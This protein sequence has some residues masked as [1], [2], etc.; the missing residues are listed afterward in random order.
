MLWADFSFESV[1][2]FKPPEPT[3]SAPQRLTLDDPRVVKRY[4]KV[5]KQEHRRLKL[6]KRGFDIQAAIPMGL[7]TS[8]C[9]EY[10]KL[11]H[12]DSCAR[13]HA[14]KKCRKLTMGAVPFSED[15]KKATSAVDLWEL[16]QRKRDGIPTSAK[17]I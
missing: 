3:Y 16:L 1:F 10:E 7:Q 14:T 4:N 8:H 13:K 17:K 6:R 11:A 12:L 2:G 5:L 15:F 9:I